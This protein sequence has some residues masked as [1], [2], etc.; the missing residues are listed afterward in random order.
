MYGKHTKTLATVI[1]TWIG[2]LK[3]TLKVNKPRSFCP[4]KEM[5]NKIKV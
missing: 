5:I 1:S 4:A 2:P 3:N